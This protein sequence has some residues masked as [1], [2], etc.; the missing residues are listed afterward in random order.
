MRGNVYAKRKKRLKGNN[1]FLDVVS[2]G[3]TMNAILK[4]ELIILSELLFFCKI[5]V[6][7]FISSI[8]Y[9]VR[10]INNVKRFGGIHIWKKLL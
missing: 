7:L 4:D 8:Y 6:I 1:I 2:V 10:K 9:L 5:Y 3:A